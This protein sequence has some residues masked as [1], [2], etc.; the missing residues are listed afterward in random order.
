MVIK[1]IGRGVPEKTKLGKMPVI[2]LRLLRSHLPDLRE[3]LESQTL[4]ILPLR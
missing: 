1:R 4:Q 3:E 2:L